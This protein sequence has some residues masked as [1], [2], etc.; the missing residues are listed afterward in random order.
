MFDQQCNTPGCAFSGGGDPGE[1]SLS[2]G[3]LM[4]SEIEKL[5]DTTSDLIPVFDEVA[6][7]KYITWN[8]NQWVSV[9]VN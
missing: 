2:S 5:L 4:Y 7:V 3:T 1:C 6:A 8:E 9:S